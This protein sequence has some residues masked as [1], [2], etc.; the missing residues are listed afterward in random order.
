MTQM[1]SAGMPELSVVD[2]VTYIREKLMPEENDEKVCGLCILS[3]NH[4]WCNMYRFEALTVF[5]FV[6]SFVQAEDSF[7]KEIKN[8]L[9]TVS[10]RIGEYLLYDGWGKNF[11]LRYRMCGCPQITPFTIS[12]TVS[13]HPVVSSPCV[14]GVKE[15]EGSAKYPAG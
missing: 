3:E 4:S 8:S 5:F 10:R 6:H 2:D 9:K 15:L 7:K 14:D 11:T 13:D 12:S 1:V